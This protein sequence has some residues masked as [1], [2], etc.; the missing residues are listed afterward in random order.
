M[1]K[2]RALRPAHKIGKIG[3]DQTASR[4]M[5]RHDISTEAGATD[6][7]EAVSARKLALMRAALAAGRVGVETPLAG[8]IDMDGVRESV[9]DLRQSFPAHFEHSFAVKANSMSGVLALLCECGM[10]AEVASEGE[11]AQ[12]L[13]AGFAPGAMVFDEPAKTAAVIGEAIKTGVNL[14]IDNFQEFERVVAAVARHGARARIGFRLNPQTGAGRIAAMST[15]T[16]TSKFGVP[17]QDAGVS[18][19]LI[20]LYAAHPWLTALHTHAGSQGCPMPLMAEAIAAMV[21]LAEAINDRIGARQVQTLDI[22]GGLSVNFESEAIRP[23][24]QDYADFLKARVPLLFTGQ[25]RVLTEFGR[26]IMAKNG[27]ILARV[28]YTKRAGGRPIAITQGGAQIAAR[29]VFMPKSWP[30]RMTAHHADGRLKSGPSLA[31]DIAGPCCFSGDKLAS[32]YPLPR[33]EPGDIIAVHDTGA[34]YFSN[35]F[36]YNSHPAAPVHGFASTGDEFAI[37]TLR[38]AQTIEAMMAVIG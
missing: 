27:L 3:A 38:P 2:N 34:Y 24:F 10:S 29:T 7:N 14:N 12:A 31:Q 18:E 8:F 30:L 21:E 20:E 23:R 33:L 19:R 25:Y 4:T 35:P 1:R 6:A 22:G 16:A 36:Y 11:I 32:G 37:H 17:L 15:A 28:E 9:A 5:H 13:R 26:A